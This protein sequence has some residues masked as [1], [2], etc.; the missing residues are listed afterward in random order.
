MREGKTDA[1]A[2][3]L[4]A[5]NSFGFVGGVRVADGHALADAFQQLFELAK[6]EPNV[7]EVRF[8]ARKH[9][10][11]DLHTL[12]L[13]IDESD[14][15]ARQLLGEN[16]DIAIATGP[17]QLYFALGKGSDSLLESIVDKSREIGPQQ[18]SLLDLRVAMKPMMSFLA[19][20]D[21]ENEQQQVLAEAIERTEGGDGIQ[22]KVEQIDNGLR[23]RLEIE[24]GVLV[25]I[26]HA[27][28][29]AGD[30]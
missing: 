22:L 29:E 21:Q 11:L 7:P 3:L 6:H 28:R 9:G 18:V 19:S 5:P 25:L 17:E 27:S 13:P 12:V 20:I 14:V 15:D 30:N 24:E 1:G 8:Y 10:D 4:L 16:V 2:T 26:G 23:A